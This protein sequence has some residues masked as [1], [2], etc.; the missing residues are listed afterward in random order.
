MVCPICGSSEV[1]DLVYHQGCYR[2][3]SCGHLFRINASDFDYSFYENH[4]YWF[5]DEQE[6]LQAYQR[7]FLGFFQQWINTIPTVYNENIQSIE[8]GAADGDF[9]VEL[10]WWMT[11][12]RRLG[13]EFKF[14]YNEL[15]DM[16]RGDYDETGDEE[17]TRYIGP[18]EEVLPQISA[19]NLDFD[20]IFLIDVIEHLKSPD[21]IFDMANILRRG[22]KIF[23]V[24]DNAGSLNG[25]DSLLYHA[26]H[27]NVF[28]QKSFERFIEFS[29][30]FSI[31]KIWCS[32]Q[33]QLFAILTQRM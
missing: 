21:T 28:S 14:V 17:I 22:G 1:I 4:D 3:S 25:H 6:N 2:C 27:L 33:G 16:L 9:L 29:G 20:N 19:D 12:H 30:T 7:M 32:P 10:K 13:K 18:I 11:N 15:V 24:T 31:N 23:I 26:E 8:F 5:K